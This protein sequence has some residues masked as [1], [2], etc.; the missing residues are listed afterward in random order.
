MQTAEYLSS[1]CNQAHF[2]NCEIGQKGIFA[3]IAYF[4]AGVSPSVTV[5]NGAQ[6]VGTIAVPDEVRKNRTFSVICSPDDDI[7]FPFVES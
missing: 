6:R 4:D 3:G 2:V 1:E 7:S 5:W